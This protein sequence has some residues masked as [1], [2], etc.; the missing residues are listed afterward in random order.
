[1]K[2]NEEHVLLTYQLEE[3]DSYLSQD[4]NS[5]TP[6]EVL[7][8]LEQRKS[9]LESLN[10]V[11]SFYQAVAIQE[12][13][14]AVSQQE[15][16][17]A[18]FAASF[19]ET[20][21]EVSAVR[22]RSNSLS[23]TCSSISNLAMEISDI[24]PPVIPLGRSSSSGQGVKMLATTKSTG[25]SLS[26][27]RTILQLSKALKTMSISTREVHECVSCFKKTNQGN[28]LSTTCN[29]FY[30]TECFRELLKVALKDK[31]LIPVKCCRVVIDQ[32][33]VEPYLSRE[34]YRKFNS[35]LIQNTCTNKMQ[36]LVMSPTLV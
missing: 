12:E 24:P 11:A 32:S 25:L 7:Y 2:I 29:H 14:I 31:S 21:V 33:S 10:C 27:D 22:S 5:L 28:L 13:L 4:S 1:M 20:A 8:F 23:S 9:L 26:S 6:D 18:L 19:A 30:C 3:L 35:F 16:S 15:S 17:D 36:W 34:D